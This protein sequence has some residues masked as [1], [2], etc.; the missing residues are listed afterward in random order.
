MLSLKA[1]FSLVTLWASMVAAQ[2][3]TITEPSSDRWWV[4]QSINTLRWNCEQTTYTNWT[5][6]ITNSDVNVLSGPLALIAIQWNYD[7]SKSMTPGEQLKPGTGYVMQF[8]NALNSTDV[9]ASS[10]PFEVKALGSTYPPEYTSTGIPGTTATGTGSS[11]NSTAAPTTTSTPS[12]NNGAMANT[13]ISALLGLA[14]LGA[15]GLAF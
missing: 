8:A 11:S 6:L 14:V 15:I 3:L 2:Q 13:A 1:I 4:A 9:W 10:Q 12:V 5:V 7:C